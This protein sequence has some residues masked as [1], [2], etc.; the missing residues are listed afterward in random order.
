MITCRVLV[1]K[2]RSQFGF[3]FAW[4]LFGKNLHLS[5]LH[6]IF[7]NH[8]FVLMR[9]IEILKIM[10]S[11]QLFLEILKKKKP[12]SPARTFWVFFLNFFKKQ[13]MSF[14]HNFL[15]FLFLSLRKINIPPKFDVKLINEKKKNK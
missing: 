7:V 9:G 12:K 5:V 2:K 1:R 3:L 6:Q 10:T 11:T 15:L 4:I 14:G 8:W 13:K